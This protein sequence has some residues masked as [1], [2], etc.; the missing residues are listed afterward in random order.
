MR[1]LFTETWSPHGVLSLTFWLNYSASF[2]HWISSLSYPYSS[3]LYILNSSLIKQLFPDPRRRC[4]RFEFPA[5]TGAGPRQ[6]RTLTLMGEALKC[7]HSPACGL[8]N[9]RIQDLIILQVH[10]S[11]HSPLHGPSFFFFLLIKKNI[12]LFLAVLDLCCCVGFSL[13]AASVGYS[14]LWCRGFSL[15]WLLL[16]CSTLSRARGLQLLRHMGSVVVAARL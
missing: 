14:T 11:Y 6:L 9:G 8:P 15:Q 3:T 1:A 2:L 7:N 4:P 12:Y 13:F 10:P 16:L 5:S